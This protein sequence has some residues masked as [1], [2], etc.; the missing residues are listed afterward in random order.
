[1]VLRIIA[2]CQ[3]Q[4]DNKFHTAK[5]KIP[6]FLIRDPNDSPDFVKKNLVKTRMHSSAMHTAH[7]LTVSQHALGRRVCLGGQDVADTPWDQRQTL[8][9][10]DRQTPVKTKPSQT[11]FAGGN[12]SSAWNSFNEY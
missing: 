5:A 4:S 3:K 6:I 12:N 10:V 9:S 7:L 1:M 11:L 2:E 8:P